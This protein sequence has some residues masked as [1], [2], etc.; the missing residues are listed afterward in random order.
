LGQSVIFRLVRSILFIESP[1][2]SI[3]DSFEETQLARILWK[4]P[5]QAVPLVLGEHEL[6]HQLI[7][8]GPPVLIRPQRYCR[9]ATNDWQDVGNQVD[10]PLRETTNVMDPSA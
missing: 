7:Y 10:Q 3:D 5:A 8:D 4:R 1:A 2:Q 6:G 9:R